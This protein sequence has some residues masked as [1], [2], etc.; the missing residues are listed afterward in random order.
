MY[1]I[2]KIM[3]FFNIKACQHILLHQIHQIMIFKK[4]SY[5]PFNHSP[6]ATYKREVK[7]SY[8][9][10]GIS[11]CALCGLIL[12]CFAYFNEQLCHFRG[13]RSTDFPLTTHYAVTTILRCENVLMHWRTLE[14]SVQ[15]YVQLAVWQFLSNQNQMYSSWY[16]VFHFTFVP[17][18]W[19]LIS[20]TVV[21]IKKP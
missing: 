2:W 13:P 1:S 16:M 17:I 8:C 14:G 18:H 4:A 7:W 10:G 3:C 19:F 15:S 12:D 9:S 6:I 21:E 5:D 11:G 20:R